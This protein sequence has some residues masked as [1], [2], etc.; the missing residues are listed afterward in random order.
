M[1]LWFRKLGEY[2][3]TE[4]DSEDFQSAMK[5]RLQITNKTELLLAVH[6][7]IPIVVWLLWPFP[8]YC[9]LV[10]S[11]LWLFLIIHY[12]I[13]D[14]LDWVQILLIAFSFVII[15]PFIYLLN[16]EEAHT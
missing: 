10:S 12:F 8:F 4:Y 11:P 14:I 9:V 15:V 3:K 5:E 13:V 7:H 2:L 6:L 1:S 16:F